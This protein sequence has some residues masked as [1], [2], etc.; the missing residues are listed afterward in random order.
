MMTA[1]VALAGD[2][3][4]L[5]RDEEIETTIRSWSAPIFHAAGLDPGAV[6]VYIIPETALNAFVSGGQKIFL[7]SG[8]L[9]RS[10]SPGQVKGVIAHETGHIAG[11]HLARLQEALKY[12]QL[13]SIIALVLGAGI[14]A[15]SGGEAGAAGG[16]VVM[17]GQEIAGRNLLKYTR[18]QEAAADQAAMSY[19]DRTGQ[20]SKGMEDFMRILAQHEAIYVGRGDPYMRSHP[21]TRDRVEV[22]GNH[23]ANSRWSDV[24]EP[25]QSVLA[26][27]RMRAKLLAFLEPLDRTLK[28]YPESDTSLPARYA[29]AIAYYRKGNLARALP[30]V[31]G[32][33]AEHPDD[34]YFHELRGQMLFENGHLA[35]AVQSYKV[36]VGL[37][38]DSAL[39][40]T[41]LAQAQ[42]E[43]N[44]PA[45]T[46]AA[47]A[48]L[49][50]A[51]KLEKD[52]AGSWNFLAIAY[53][54]QGQVGLSSL[55]LAEKFLI[56]GK[57][58]DARA[59]AKRAEK[60]LPHGSPSWLRAQ[61]IITVAKK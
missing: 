50:E 21:M 57:N 11:G 41:M 10:E 14:I 4:A 37:K 24:P 53:G 46:R 8:L 40:L 12:A 58:K 44:D 25:P 35:E 5:I 15:G 22:I 48:H 51:V 3:R 7:T 39:L 33:I 23:V 31:G 13:E 16:A 27:A 20:S 61:D 29:Q 55:A 59:Q 56:H 6:A 38:P 45:Q 34:P 17:G 43:L 52:N 19:L 36:A 42:L 32:L 1:F 60:A 28:E 18:G 54:R 26:H 2:A 30:L 49:I 9:M 47:T